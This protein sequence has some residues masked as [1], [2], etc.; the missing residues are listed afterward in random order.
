MKKGVHILTGSVPF[1][2][3]DGVPPGS[4]RRMLL[5]NMDWT[6]NFVVEKF[7]LV[8]TGPDLVTNDLYTNANF[9]VV[10]ATKENGAQYGISQPG[11]VAGATVKDNRQIGWAGWSTNG[12][13]NVTRGPVLL[14]DRIIVDDLFING[15]VVN[16]GTGAAQS[17]V[18]DI[19]YV[20][21]LR[22]VTTS[23]DEAIMMM[24]KEN[25]QDSIRH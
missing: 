11:V 10:L 3:A 6:R 22:Q 4:P 18:Q 13:V 8:I 15:W 12:G 7:E 9:I 5:N 23:I 21:T 25:A 16:A 17:L 20:I 2:D 14:P 24:L 1:A 19:G